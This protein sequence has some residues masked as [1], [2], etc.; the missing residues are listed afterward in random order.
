[1]GREGSTRPH[2]AGRGPEI[3]VYVAEPAPAAAD[4]TEVTYFRSYDPVADAPD[5]SRRAEEVAEGFATGADLARSFD[6]RWRQAEGAARRKDPGRVVR[7]F[8]PSL[9]L[10]DYLATR[11]PEMTVHGLDLADALRREPWITPEGMAIVGDI[12]TG[13]LAAAP[14][15]ALQWTEVTFI[16]AGTGRRALSVEERA[17]LGDRAAL[18]PLL[19]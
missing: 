5:I 2:V 10:P 12:L 7:T 15:A 13:L 19:A 16:E 3:L 17:I 8:R 18:F 9:L 14:P 6:E 4:A 1:V 11:L